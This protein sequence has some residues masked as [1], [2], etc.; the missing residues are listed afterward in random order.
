MLQPVCFHRR[1]ACLLAAAAML[2]LGGCRSMGFGALNVTNQRNGVEVERN[3]P[4][5]PEQHLSLD[6]YRPAH[7]R[8]APVVVFFYGGDWTHGKRQW[9]RFVGATLA[10]HGV[11]AVIPDYRKYPQVRLDGF[12]QDAAHAVAWVHEHASAF[13]GDPGSLFV[14]GHS[15]GGQIAGLLATDPSW[16]AADGLS[17]NDLAGFIGLAGV[18]DFVPLSKGETGMRK[19]FGQLPVEQRRADP[20]TFVRAGDPP[21]LLLQGAADHQI[22]ASES[23]ALARMVRA[24]HGEVELK[25][26]PGV[27]HMGL[28]LSLSRPLRQQAPALRDVLH[29]IRAHERNVPPDTDSR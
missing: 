10:A 5:A 13:G 23:V 18:Y 1:L 21:M 9:Y 15:S 2:V 14:M 12:M 24:V 6:L 17:L 11:I 28:V 26:Y 3:L 22:Q 29:F 27:G 7:A 20:A 4:F 25:V 19:I 8:H 16:L